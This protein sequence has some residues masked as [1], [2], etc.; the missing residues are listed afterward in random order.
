MPTPCKNQMS[1]IGGEASYR[2][3]WTAAL[4]SSDSLAEIPELVGEGGKAAQCR[5]CWGSRWA[6]LPSYHAPL[7]IG[8]NWDWIWISYENSNAAK[9][10]LILLLNKLNKAMKE[11][12]IVFFKKFQIP[13]DFW[14][15]W[16]SSL[17]CDLG[18]VDV[19]GPC[20]V[21]LIA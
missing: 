7:A 11:I 13:V 5:G 10:V 16:L 4:E 2:S 12:E 3:S 15:S 9:L 19:L 1:N 21:F 18:Q 20:R 6:R 8:G 17:L 14:L